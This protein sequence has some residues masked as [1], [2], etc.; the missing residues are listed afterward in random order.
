MANL[1]QLTMRPCHTGLNLKGKKEKARRWEEGVLG[2]FALSA[3]ADTS[4]ELIN[5][6][7]MGAVSKFM[8]FY[9]NNNQYLPKSLFIVAKAHFCSLLESAFKS[10][11][12]GF[13]LSCESI[14]DWRL[15]GNVLV[16]RGDP[17]DSDSPRVLH[18]FKLAFILGHV[19]FSEVA[20]CCV[21]PQ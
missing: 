7:T 19:S 17:S 14:T 8:V 12:R 5:K 3:S 21:C 15:L 20:V 10:S 1:E 13:V 18:H 9:W 4:I 6:W 11:L 16:T 2:C